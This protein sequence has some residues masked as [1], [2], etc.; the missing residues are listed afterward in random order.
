MI[1]CGEFIGLKG[2]SGGNIFKTNI[3]EAMRSDPFKRMRSRV[4]EDISECGGCVFRNICGAPCPAE[5]E[6]LGGMHRPSVF[7]NFYK[8][9]INYAFKLIAKGEEGYCFREGSLDN[10][11]YRYRLGG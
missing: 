9:V 11:E 8:E 7:C 6:A 1:P 4:A 10:L 2:F 3:S 5:L